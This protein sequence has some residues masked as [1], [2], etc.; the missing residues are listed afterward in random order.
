MSAR[1]QTLSGLP[2]TRV[3][4]PEVF[5]GRINIETPVNGLSFGVSGNFGPNAVTE[6]PGRA[7]SDNGSRFAVGGHAEYMKEKYLL[8]AEGLHTSI[9]NLAN[10]HAAYAELAWKFYGEWQAAYR[11]DW[12]VIDFR[13]TAL[14]ASVPSTIKKHTAYTFGLNYWLSPNLV[15]KTSYSYI[16]GN[17]FA[18]PDT[19]LLDFATPYSSLYPGAPRLDNTTHYFE[20]GAQFSF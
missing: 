5:G 16:R 10:V 12:T 2:N 17:R 15:A 6:V 11:L 18:N 3:K 1:L 4:T 7:L 19:L 13:N 8:R 9:Q 14:S 20:A